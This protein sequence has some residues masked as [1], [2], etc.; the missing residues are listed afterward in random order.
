MKVKELIEKLKEYD[1]E[2]EVVTY[3]ID[4]FYKPISCI[5]TLIKT[6]EIGVNGD[7]FDC[8]PYDEE[9]REDYLEEDILYVGLS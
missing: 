3:D 4:T 7:Y 5:E 2:M 6:G 1:D 8:I 9:E